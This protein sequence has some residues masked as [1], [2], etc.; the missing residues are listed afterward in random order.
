MPALPLR[1]AYF[2]GFRSSP[3]AKKGLH[4]RDTLA[5]EGA[6]FLLPDLN[7]PSFAKLSV[8]AMLA[9]LDRLHEDEGRPAW[10]VVGSSLG[11]WLAARWAE[12]HPARVDRLVLL[13]PAFD[14]AHRWP[15]MMDAGDFERWRRERE[16]ETEDASGAPARL[17]FTFYEEASA[18]VQWPSVRCPVTVVH[19][20]RDETV[21]IASSRRWVSD[22][23][24]AKLI[25]VDDT[26]DLLASLDVVDRAVRDTFD[27][28]G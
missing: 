21:P 12:L 1:Y 10:R 11:G 9:H 20:T 28:P 7:Q 8:R 15:E 5:P 19:G 3:S 26:H 17:H 16:I 22:H 6:D 18:E 24:G 23:P 25:E 2:H 4:L 27:L 13:C 14:L